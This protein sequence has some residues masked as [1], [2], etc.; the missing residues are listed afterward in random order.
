MGSLEQLK[1][2][3]ADMFAKSEN[4][5]EIESL[6]AIKKAC[7]DVEA[8]HNKLQAENKELLK[9]YKELVTHTSFKDQHNKPSNTIDGNVVS[10]D[11]AIAQ[12]IKELK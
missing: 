1:N 12:A 4:K 5:A 2:L 3:V 11:D 6:S 10:F 9:D 7:D 8:E